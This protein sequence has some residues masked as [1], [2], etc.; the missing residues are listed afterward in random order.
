MSA[1][2][3]LLTYP[4]QTRI[5]VSCAL[6]GLLFDLAGARERGCSQFSV[7]LTCAL[8][9][10]RF[11]SPPTILSQVRCPLQDSRSSSPFHDFTFDSDLCWP[12]LIG[13]FP[14]CSSVLFYCCS[15]C[16]DSCDYII[17][18]VP[19]CRVRAASSTVGLD[20]ACMYCYCRFVQV[21]YIIGVLY[22]DDNKPHTIF[23]SDERSD[24]THSSCPRAG[25]IY[26]FK[27]I[28]ACLS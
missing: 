21:L 28:Y 19:R 24:R 9:S 14:V 2:S 18:F 5:P 23:C 6:Y 11:F 12:L 25:V 15:F 22:L 4:H 17:H 26:L 8:K 10:S 3:G 27:Y 7:G 1:T 13:G 16:C 20:D